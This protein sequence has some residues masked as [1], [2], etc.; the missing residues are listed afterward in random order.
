[1]ESR[2]EW[3][4]VETAPVE[5]ADEIDAR[6]DEI[7]ERPEKIDELVEDV[8]DPEHLDEQRLDEQRV[9]AQFASCLRALLE[10]LCGWPSR[11]SL[12]EGLS[13]RPDCEEA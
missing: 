6:P 11:S 9:V 7:V 3:V 10:L 4:A 12:D 8:G 2:V 5:Q 13:D 1:M